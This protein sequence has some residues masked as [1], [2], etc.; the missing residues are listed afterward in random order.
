MPEHDLK[1]DSFFRRNKFNRNKFNA[2]AR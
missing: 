2:L 1:K